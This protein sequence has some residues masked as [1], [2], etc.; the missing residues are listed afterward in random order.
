MGI[1]KDERFRKF[2]I[3]KTLQ[4]LQSMQLPIE[5][6]LT[7]LDKTS[8]LKKATKRI[9]LLSKFLKTVDDTG[10]VVVKIGDRM[11][12][13]S[14]TPGKESLAHGF[15]FGG[16]AMAGFDFL[17]IPIIYLSAYLLGEEVPVNLSNNA[18]WFYSAILLG[19]TITALAVPVTAPYI[20]FVTAGL[21]LGVGTFLLGK[22]LYERYQL[23][24]EKR[25]LKAEIIRE[26]DEMLKI[27]DKAKHLESL[28]QNADNEEQIAAILSEI[29]VVQ[30]DY[31]RQKK[32]IQDLKNDELQLE[33]QIKNLDTMKV[34]DRT[35]AVALSA[36]TIVALA[37]TLFF[38]PV[39]GGMLAGIAIAGGAYFVARVSAPLIK[40]TAVWLYNKLKSTPSESAESQ[41]IDNKPTLSN[42]KGKKIENT[43]QIDNELVLPP[44]DAEKLISA[45][46]GEYK[47]V[48]E[49]TEDVLVGLSVNIDR[50]K[51]KVKTE[52]K[53]EI[54]EASSEELQ[55]FSSLSPS[56]R[57]LGSRKL[58]A[59]ENDDE[60]GE[61]KSDT[62]HPE[63]PKI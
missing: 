56:P 48:H 54:E 53:E 26:E 61:S 36:L 3:E 30:E 63:L 22:T 47:P 6:P 27:Q 44:I 14:H 35:V 43:S 49:S 19:L 40:A 57:T 15:A 58:S 33:Q 37:V 2:E 29:S 31:N 55:H 50:L 39:G 8:L 60:E 20:A 52:K 17:R 18:K 45:D 21:S 10:D 9:P 32:Q 23:G 28:L 7:P 42:E 59:K 41:D 46:S 24:R 1:T 34:V 5:Y 25:K 13:L 12:S 4:L 62:E 51:E 16:V 11:T 38:P